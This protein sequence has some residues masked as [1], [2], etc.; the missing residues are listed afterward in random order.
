MSGAPVISRLHPETLEARPRYRRTFLRLNPTPAWALAAAIE[1][2]GRRHGPGFSYQEGRYQIP[3]GVSL[4]A[5]ALALLSSARAAADLSKA[6]GLVFLLLALA[7][8]EGRWWTVL[9]GPS[10]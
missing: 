5:L 4:L 1:G 7:P 9:L 2:M 10:A 6:A 8:A 3:L